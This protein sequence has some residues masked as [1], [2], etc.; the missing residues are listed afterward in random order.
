MDAND[1][2]RFFAATPF[3]AFYSDNQ[4]PWIQT[5]DFGG[6]IRSVYY[7]GSDSLIYG[8]DFGIYLSTDNGV[9][10]SYLS[11]IDPGTIYI[12]DNY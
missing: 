6:T 4:S 7:I 3:G 1:D 10:G 11:G 12:F 8:T 5:M 9:S 2:G